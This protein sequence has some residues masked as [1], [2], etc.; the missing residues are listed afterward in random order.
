M[1]LTWSVYIRKSQT[2]ILL[3][4]FTFLS[5]L[6]GVALMKAKTEDKCKYILLFIQCLHGY[7]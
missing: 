5:S 1:Q 7:H 6:S 2:I 3:H 4:R